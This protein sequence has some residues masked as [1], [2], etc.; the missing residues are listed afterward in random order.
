VG[1]VDADKV[2]IMI[3]AVIVSMIIMLL[4]SGQVSNFVNNHPGIKMLALAFLLMIG[5]LL[6]AESWHFHVP[7]GYVYFSMTF[8]LFVELLKMRSEKKKPAR[9]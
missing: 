3:A 4:F 1:M 8:A 9:H 6:V 7:K 2:I 5:T